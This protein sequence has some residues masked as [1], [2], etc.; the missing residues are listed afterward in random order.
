MMQAIHHQD[1]SAG[2]HRRCPKRSRIV[3]RL[4]FTAVL[5]GLQ[6]LLMQLPRSQA[7]TIAAINLALLTVSSAVGLY[8]RSLTERSFLAAFSGSGSFAVRAVS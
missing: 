8:G 1:K 2:V 5:C 3:I 7:S 4:L 6:P